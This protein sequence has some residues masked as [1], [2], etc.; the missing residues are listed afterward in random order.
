MSWL[1]T[2]IDNT[3][4]LLSPAAALRRQAARK[5]TE[6]FSNYKGASRSRLSS[7]WQVSSGSA[8]YDLLPDLPLLRERSR[9]LVRNDPVAAGAVN[10]LVD[11]I[12]GTGIRPQSVINGSR[13][14][15]TDEKAAEIRRACEAAWERWI[16]TADISRRFNFYD[17][18][19][20]VMRSIILNGESLVMPVRVDRTGVPYSIALELIE[21]DRVEAPG[22]N[23]APNGRLNRRSGVELGR[24]GNPVAYYIRVSHPGDGVYERKAK[25]THRRIPAY[26]SNGRKLILHLANLHRPGQTRGEPMLSPVLDAFKSLSSYNE[27]TLVSQRLSACYSMFITRDDPVNASINRSDDVIGSQRLTDIEPGMVSYLSPGEQI[28]FSNTS[29]LSTSYNDFV[30][31]QL[32]TIGGAL[33]LPIELLTKD[34]S[35]T[36]YSSARA[37][38][39]EARRVFQRWQRMIIDHLCA[40][41]YEMVIEEAFLRGDIPVRDFASVRE[42]LTRSRWVPPSYGWVDPKKEVEAA[43][44]AINAGLSSLAVEAAAQGRDWE[45]VLEQQA[46]EKALRRELDLRVEGE[47]GK[48]VEEEEEEVTDG[49]D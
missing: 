47:T 42:E 31:R 5:A 36:N 13:M 11:N 22:V 46:R 1:S 19:A 25:R 8:D 39:L 43:S 29:G 27:A 7:H 18:Q 23:D 38:L 41:V 26:D 15:V 45:Q 28:S 20:T 4:S 33:G 14:G 21:P 49:E 37:A 34:F 6:A 48:P 32:K 44:A 17:L 16:H 3:V 35:Q 10:T 2:V 24:H 30:A 9:E 40:P 12:V